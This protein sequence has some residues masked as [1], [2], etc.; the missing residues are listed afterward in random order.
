MSYELIGDIHGCNPSI[1]VL[2]DR[3]SAGLS[4]N[5]YT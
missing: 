4:L 3:F 1:R 2:L 5:Y